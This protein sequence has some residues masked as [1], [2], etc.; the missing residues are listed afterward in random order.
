MFYRLKQC[1]FFFNKP[2]YLHVHA[3]MSR[4]KKLF[5]SW[6]CTKNSEA[7]IIS[8]SSIFYP[9]SGQQRLAPLRNV[10]TVQVK[11]QHFREFTRCDADVWG[12]IIAKHHV[13]NLC[14]KKKTWTWANGLISFFNFQVSISVSASKIQYWSDSSIDRVCQIKTM[15]F[16]SVPSLWLYEQPGSHG[17]RRNLLC[18]MKKGTAR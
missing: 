15:F 7:Q 1:F 18:G 12:Q 14:Q 8:F 6:Q 3:G 11:V 2:W 17:T 13:Q 4:G 9:C 16:H 10:S 5:L